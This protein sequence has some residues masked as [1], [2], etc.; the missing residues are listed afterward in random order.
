MNNL[1]DIF[2]KSFDN[3]GLPTAAAKK[4]NTYLRGRQEDPELAVLGNNALVA[5]TSFGQDAGGAGIQGRMVNGGAEFAMNSQGNL[6][7]KAPVVISNGVNKYLALWVNTIKADHSILA[8]QRYISSEGAVAA[9]VKD[10]T[11]GEVNIVG[12]EVARRKTNTKALKTPPQPESVATMSLAAPPPPPAANP[13][14]KRIAAAEHVNAAKP[15][16]ANNSVHQPAPEPTPAN[17][18]TARRPGNTRLSN[19]AETALQSMARMRQGA[20]NRMNMRRPSM[21]RNNSSAYQ[22]QSSLLHQARARTQGTRPGMVRPTGL[23]GQRPGTTQSSLTRMGMLRQPQQPTQM[24]N[25]NSGFSTAQTTRSTR[26]G[27]QLTRSNLRFTPSSSSVIGRQ[28]Q[29][30]ARNSTR[31]PSSAMNRMEFLRNRG[32]SSTAAAQTAAAQ[33]VNA[34][35]AQSGRDYYLRYQSQSGSRYQVQSSNDQNSWSNVGGVRSGRGGTDSVRVV[36]GSAKYYR[37]V[38]SN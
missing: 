25:L 23:Y 6:H 1:S 34:S 3:A 5:W 22:A 36:P 31:Q 17:N 26:L 13:A 27:P 20:P 24:A 29:Q 37:V 35:L 32:N 8:A 4:H 12:A 7:Q 9:G 14:A 30:V 18:A 10:V 33:P 16:V 21:M 11:A 38:R 28:G 15:Q 19:A 2:V